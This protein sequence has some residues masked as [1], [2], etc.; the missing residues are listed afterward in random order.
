L[1]LPEQFILLCGCAD[2]SHQVYSNGQT[3]KSSVTVLAL[4]SPTSSRLQGYRRIGEEGRRVQG[5]S[6]ASDPDSSSSS[7]FCAPH[8]GGHR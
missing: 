5:R 6:L 7:T 1:L 2:T 8:E 4:D 3:K